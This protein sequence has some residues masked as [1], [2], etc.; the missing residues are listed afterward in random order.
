MSI[1]LKTHKMLWGRGANRCAF[2]D[3][4]LELVMDASETDDEALVGEECHIIAREPE[5]PRGDHSLPIGSR[6]KYSNLILLCS[7]HHTLVDKQPH[8]YTVQCLQEIKAT[9]EKWVRESLTGFD[10]VKQ[11][12][13]ERY[14]DY[15]EKW[16]K[17]V[18]LDTW[19]YWLDWLFYGDQPQITKEHYDSLVQLCFWLASR[20]WPKRYPELEAAF[21]NFRRVL[22]DLLRVFNAHAF[23]RDVPVSEERKV[24]D[25]SY[26]TNKFYKRHEG[27]EYDVWLENYLFYLDFMLDLGLELTRAANYICDRVRQSIDPTFRLREGVAL[28]GSWSEPI[29]TEY[30]I[31]ERTLYPYPGLKPFKEDRKLRDKKY[32]KAGMKEYYQFLEVI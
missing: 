24:E 15:I 30:Q 8:K 4:R 29:R 32:F 6:D 2:P 25:I 3:C 17:L 31:D 14:A 27:D 20:I 9:H 11:R 12:D 1:S 22:I 21:E 23:R 16:V 10:P 26:M 18:Y 28:I 7:T 19:R 5:G 13:E